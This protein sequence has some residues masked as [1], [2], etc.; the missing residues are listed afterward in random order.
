MVLVMSTTRYPV[1]RQTLLRLAAEADA[2]PRSVARV[3]RGERVRGHVGAKIE[4]VLRQRGLEPV[5]EKG[6][7]R[8]A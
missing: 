7:G 2:D 3:L 8:A 5:P 6:D 1:D 4:R